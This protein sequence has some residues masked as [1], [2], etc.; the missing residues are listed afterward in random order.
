MQTF[1]SGRWETQENQNATPQNKTRA[2][3]PQA[4]HKKGRHTLGDTH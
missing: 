3:K 2:G 4:S 1:L